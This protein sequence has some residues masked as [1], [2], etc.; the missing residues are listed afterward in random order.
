ML[1]TALG[2]IFLPA[3]GV[4]L[5]IKGPSLAAAFSDQVPAGV[6]PSAVYGLTVFLF[7]MINPANASVSLEGK[8]I[9][10]PQS[11]PVEPFRVLRAKFLLQFILTAV[12]AIFIYVC[13]VI[14]LPMT[15]PAAVTLFTAILSAAL[16]MSLFY[17]HL[18]ASFTNLTWTSELIPIKQSAGVLI[19]MFSTWGYGAVTGAFCAAIGLFLDV[20]VAFGVMTAAALGLSALFYSLIKNKD[21]RVFANL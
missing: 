3:A 17:L 6:I 4:F 2:V 5:L 14:S 15:V 19:A 13:A 1:N 10:I 18:G 12:P 21:S 9:W 8:S 16:M 11:L 7:S 20:S